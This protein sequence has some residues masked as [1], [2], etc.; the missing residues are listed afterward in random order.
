MA[1]SLLIRLLWL[2]NHMWHNLLLPKGK[3]RRNSLGTTLKE[4]KLIPKEGCYGCMGHGDFLCRNYIL[5]GLSVTLY[6]VYS[7]ARLQKPFG[8]IGKEI[9]NRGCRLEEVHSRK[10]FLDFKM[11]D[12]KTVM[13]QVQEFQMILHDPHAEGMKLS[14]SFQVA[15]MIEKLPPLWKDFK[16]LPEA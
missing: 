15:A 3:G 6:N 11:V 2:F 12:S 10:V 7:S 4:G 16:N 14:E 9:Q 5:N 1:T 13:N 8:V